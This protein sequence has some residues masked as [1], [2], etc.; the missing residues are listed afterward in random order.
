MGCVICKLHGYITIYID[1]SMN[2]S[3]TD[4]LNLMV[5]SHPKEGNYTSIY[6]VSDVVLSTVFLREDTA[7]IIVFLDNIIVQK[8]NAPFHDNQIIKLM[9]YNSKNTVRQVNKQIIRNHN[10]A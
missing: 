9:D 3:I 4:T 8:I 2:Y 1:N 5:E 6:G 10:S 7:Y